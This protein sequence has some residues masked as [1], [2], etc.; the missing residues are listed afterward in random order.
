MALS[1]EFLTE[2]EKAETQ[3]VDLYEIQLT[4]PV[5]TL[6]LANSREDVIEDGHTYQALSIG[7]SSVV[8]TA[9]GKANKVSLSLDNVARSFSSLVQTTRVTGLNCTIKQIFRD[10]PGHHRL[11]FVGYLANP[12]LD[13]PTFTVDVLQHVYTLQAKTPRRAYQRWCNS[14]FGDAACLTYPGKAESGTTT[15]LNDSALDRAYWFF[16]GGTLT[17]VEGTNKGQ[18]RTVS[19][20]D[21]GYIEWTSPMPAP[22]DATSRYLLTWAPRQVIGMFV[23]SGTTTRLNATGYNLYVFENG[24]VHVTGGTNAGE[25]RKITEAG[26][27]YLEWVVPMPAP[28]DASGICSVFHGCNKTLESC[29]DKHGNEN[30]YSGFLYIEDTQNLRRYGGGQ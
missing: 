14:K 9:D 3:P 15:R 6:Y 7:R 10:L 29:R 25:K 4:S 12:L 30:R 28:M 8:R 13:G 26:P 17:V 5:M 18:V 23:D 1:S 2:K 19:A 11:V 16:Y 20:S 21:T 22:I 27:D 24:I